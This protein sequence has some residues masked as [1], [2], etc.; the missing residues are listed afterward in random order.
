[1]GNNN[2]NNKNENKT[3]PFRITPGQFQDSMRIIVGNKTNATIRDLEEEEGELEEKKGTVVSIDRNKINGDGWVV[4]DEEGNTYNCSC[5]SSMYE[6]PSSVERGGILYP[7]ETVTVTFT[8]NPVLRINTIKEIHSATLDA[9]REQQK[10]KNQ[11]KTITKNADGTNDDDKD[12]DKDKDKNNKNNK[13]KKDSNTVKLDVSKWQHGDKPTTVIAKPKSAISISDSMIS[14]NY[15][16]TNSVIANE[17]SVSTFGQKTEIA[18]QAL[19]INSDE[20]KVK[21]VDFVDYIQAESKNT[22]QDFYRTFGVSVASVEDE[23]IDIEQEGNMGQLSFKG[24]DFTMSE[25]EMIVADLKNPILFPDFKQKHALLNENVDEL[26][27][28]PNGLVTI[29]ARTPYPPDEEGNPN[30]QK[31]LGT[32]NW[33]TSKMVKRNVLEIVVGEICDCCDDNYNSTV[34]YFNYCPK[35]QTWNTLSEINNKII[36][37]SCHT[38]FCANCGHDTTQSCNVKV[39]DLKKYNEHKILSES[40]HCD[41][42]IMQIPE[43]FMKEYANYCPYCHKWDYLH[44]IEEK[45]KDGQTKKLLECTSCKQ[46]YCANCSTIQ[47]EIFPRSFIGSNIKFNDYKDK[48]KKIPFIR[49]DANGRIDN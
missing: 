35:C 25:N 2:E 27:I 8:V 9:L 1:M 44:T 49:D 3:K 5:A 10:Q 13:N 45:D 4:K 48:I 19:E 29:R 11:N 39:Y 15:D 28:Y 17:E 24:F 30:K 20:I 6:L 16:N 43:N 40:T 18:T 23:F 32:F 34:S 22:I 21:H 26:F 42:C 31:I 36:C 41:Y 12:K 46:K 33:I 37:S 7:N 14:F 38:H 47:N